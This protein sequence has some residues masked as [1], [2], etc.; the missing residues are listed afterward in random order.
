MAEKTATAGIPLTKSAQALTP[1]SGPVPSYV[2]V[3]EKSAVAA[4]LTVRRMRNEKNRWD[5]IVLHLFFSG[6]RKQ[7]QGFDL[8]YCPDRI[9]WP[10]GTRMP[11]LVDLEPVYPA[12]PLSM[13]WNGSIEGTLHKITDTVYVMGISVRLPDASAI[14]A[15]GIEKFDYNARIEGDDARTIFMGTK[16]HLIR[17]GLAPADLFPRDDDTL[18]SGH[19]RAGESTQRLHDGKWGYIRRKKATRADTQP[20]AAAKDDHGLA[21]FTSTDDYRRA[22]QHLV[23]MYVGYEP[24]DCLAKFDGLKSADGYVYGITPDDRERIQGAINEFHFALRDVEVYR[25]RYDTRTGE[26]KAAAREL[27]A[28]AESDPAFQ[29]FLRSLNHGKPGAGLEE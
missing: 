2:T 29:T 15:D 21:K 26:E 6:G 19:H 27:L 16:D 14:M 10:S 18:T 5:R 17:A 11:S 22:L 13:K 28:R 20:E 4:G 25:K 23:P 9:H 7:I 12:E 1:F 24:A 8:L 3:I